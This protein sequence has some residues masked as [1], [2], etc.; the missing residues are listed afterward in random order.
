[1]LVG[2]MVRHQIQ[3]EFEV[4]VMNLLQELIKVVHRPEERIDRAIVGDI[5]AEIG[6]RRG[7]EGRDPECVNSKLHQV[8]QAAQDAPQIADAVAIAVLKRPW[9][10]LVDD[11]V[12]PPR[13]VVLLRG[14]RGGLRLAINAENV[15]GVFV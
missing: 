5:V 13:A 7:I 14:G 4:S 2:G 6:H 10:D 15:L 8:I 1:M 3:D 9:I 11:R 12:F